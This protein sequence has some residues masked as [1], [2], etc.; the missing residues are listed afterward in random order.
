MWKYGRDEELLAEK[1]K[2]EVMSIIMRFN[3]FMSF[4][5]EV[6][7]DK[8]DLLHTANFLKLCKQKIDKEIE[9]KI[10]NVKARI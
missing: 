5:S 4:N 6:S 7:G 9:E 1:A 8:S 3:G 10:S 2:D